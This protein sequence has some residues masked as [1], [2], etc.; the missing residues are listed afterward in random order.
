[1]SKMILNNVETSGNEADAIRDGYYLMRPD[2]LVITQ[3]ALAAYEAAIE[4]AER[5][6]GLLRDALLK[7]AAVEEGAMD[8]GLFVEAEKKPNWR[9]E[10]I[11]LGG[12]PKAVL[13]RTEKIDSAPR[14][15]TYVSGSKLPSGRQVAPTAD[16]SEVPVKE[17]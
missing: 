16:G 5:L 8:T 10:F 13:D 3:K 14:L 4:K 11:G 17:K 7:G 12:D 9:T 15:R 1:M 6:A 2:R